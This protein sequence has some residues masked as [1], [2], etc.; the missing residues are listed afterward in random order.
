MTAHSTAAKSDAEL[1]LT[2][3][4]DAPRELVFQMWTRPE[5]LNNWSCPKGMTIPHAE[6]DIRPGGSYRTCMRSPDGKEYWLSGVYKEIDEPERIVFTHVWD[7][8]TGRP[9]HE[10]VVTVTLREA[11]A[12]KTQLTLHQAIFASTESRDGHESG[13]S[14]AFD[15]LE[16]Y[17][18]KNG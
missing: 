9:G 7:D 6:G 12:D 14:S 18:P 13:W 11:G 15:N 17:L 10:T 2:R 16:D 1:Y 8:E 3:T 4:F 5:H